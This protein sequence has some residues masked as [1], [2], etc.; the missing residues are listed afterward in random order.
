MDTQ[1]IITANFKRDSSLKVQYIFKNGV[2]FRFKSQ[3]EDYKAGNKGMEY[4]AVKRDDA[5]L[6]KNELT[7]DERENLQ[8][9]L[10]VARE[11]LVEGGLSDEEKTKTELQV[12]ELEAKLK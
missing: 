4:Q 1:K 6:A 3:A 2:V 12:Q 7:T 11:L 10:D 9:E 5:E 8:A